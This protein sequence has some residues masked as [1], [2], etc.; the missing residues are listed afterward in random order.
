MNTEESLSNESPEVENTSQVN[1]ENELVPTTNDFR[2][3][4]SDFPL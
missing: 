2:Y 4:F 1:E 3:L